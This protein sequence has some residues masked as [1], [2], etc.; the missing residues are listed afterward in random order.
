MSIEIYKNNIYIEFWKEK[1]ENQQGPLPVLI[2]T[3]ESFNVIEPFS[4]HP[5][6]CKVTRIKEISSMNKWFV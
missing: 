2:K 4:A 6:M 3:I 5:Y 1:S